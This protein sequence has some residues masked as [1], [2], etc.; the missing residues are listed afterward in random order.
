M[1]EPLKPCECGW[2]FPVM[3]RD[4]DRPKWRVRCYAPAAPCFASTAWHNT[5]ADA[6]AAWNRRALPSR[7]EVVAILDQHGTAP[8]GLIYGPDADALIRGWNMA[9]ERIRKAVLALMRCEA[10]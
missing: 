5:E 1:S 2:A 8:D 6:I 9:G 10:T 7:E 3:R 4:Y